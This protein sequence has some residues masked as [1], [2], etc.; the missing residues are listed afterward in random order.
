MSK[1]DTQEIDKLIGLVRGL[2]VDNQKE[3]NIGSKDCD[4]KQITLKNAEDKARK[5]EEQHLEI[6]EELEAAR[7]EVE[8]LEQI[9]KATRI[10]GSEEEMKALEELKDCDLLIKTRVPKIDEC[11]KTLEEIKKL[12]EDVE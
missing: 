11:T 3:I 8:R 7:A 10:I 1:V 9:D 4:A 6:F 5:T 12:L 2:L